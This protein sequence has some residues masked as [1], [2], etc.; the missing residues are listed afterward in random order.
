MFVKVVKRKQKK[1]SS[2]CVASSIR[3]KLGYSKFMTRRKF[4]VMKGVLISG[5]LVEGA[6]H[7]KT[8]SSDNHGST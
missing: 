1:V 4:L 3:R 6:T 5:Q 2:R 7:L 8:T